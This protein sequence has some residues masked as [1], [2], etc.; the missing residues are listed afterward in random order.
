MKKFSVFL[1][2]GLLVLGTLGLSRN[3]VAGT[4]L[5][6]PQTD[7][8][9][10]WGSIDPP[11]STTDPSLSDPNDKWACWLATASNVLNYTGWNAPAHANEQDIYDWYLLSSG[12]YDVHSGGG[13]ATAYD[14]Y[15]A[16]FYPSEN[17]LDYFHQWD[18]DPTILTGIDTYLTA[19]YGLYLSIIY[20]GA[21]MGHAI[22]CWGYETDDVTGD[23]T[24]VY[25]TDSDDESSE[26]FE[27][28]DLN[29]VSVTLTGGR[30]YMGDQYATN[31]YYIRRIDAFEAGI[32]VPEPATMLLLGSGLIGLATL[33]RRRFFNK[34]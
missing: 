1:C 20:D 18:D 34:N 12:L 6:G 3:A 5:W 30:W 28:P 11:F 21:D 26:P 27:D 32:P 22:T 23:Y 13:G 17:Y 7:V 31:G 10:Y 14:T 2:A 24:H 19:G 15:L 25:V 4:F 29:K 16:S 8:D 33:G 9:K